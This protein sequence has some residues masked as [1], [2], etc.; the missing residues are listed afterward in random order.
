M[1]GRKRVPDCSDRLASLAMTAMKTS[2]SKSVK[3]VSK[4][5]LTQVTL[6]RGPTTQK[7]MS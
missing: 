2:A 5:Q 4:A 1:G 6:C 3:S 7:E